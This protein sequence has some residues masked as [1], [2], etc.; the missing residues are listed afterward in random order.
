MA[1]QKQ[2][3][4]KSAPAPALPRLDEIGWI[5]HGIPAAL[6]VASLVAAYFAYQSN[7]Q[8][9]LTVALLAIGGLLPFTTWLS[10]HGS[11]AGWSF[12]IALSI[13]LAVMTLFGAPK[14][15]TLTGMHIGVALVFPAAFTFAAFALLGQAHRYKS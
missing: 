15:R 1:D 6:G 10:V 3:K 2:S 13:V 11:R 8:I 5:G 14:I 4:S 7:I 12:L 9:T